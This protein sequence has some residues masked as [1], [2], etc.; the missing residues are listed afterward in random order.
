MLFFCGYSCKESGGSPSA[1]VPGFYLLQLGGEKKMVSSL[2]FAR[3]FSCIFPC[4]GIAIKEYRQF[5]QWSVRINV[6]FRAA[7]LS[8]FFVGMVVFTSANAVAGEECASLIT[9]RCEVCHYK[10]RI[11]ESLGQKSKSAW[12][13][14]VGNMVSYGAQLS[15][16]EQLSLVNCL[17]GPAADITALCEK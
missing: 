4:F 15:K 5:R 12:K 17:S 1:G 7:T 9:S 10:T 2:T 8:F 16:D 11:C 3:I 6:M 13:R 14:T